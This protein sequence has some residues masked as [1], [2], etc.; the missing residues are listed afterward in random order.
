[1]S[2][3]DASASKLDK[4][5]VAAQNIN[6]TADGLGKLLHGWQTSVDKVV[7]DLS[8]AYAAGVHTVTAG[9]M[10]ASKVIIATGQTGIVGQ[11][12]QHYSSGS[13]NGFLYVEN[14]GSTLYVFD[15]SGSALTVG[16][17][18]SWTVF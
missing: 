12:V 18:I 10:N 11:I 15:G 13:Q 6:G 1:M 9:E 2:I 7:S 8:A 5:M 3:T 17:T 16:D 4:S 14:T